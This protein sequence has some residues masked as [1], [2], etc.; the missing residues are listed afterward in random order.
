MCCSNKRK[1]PCIKK[2]KKKRRKVPY[3]LST[4]DIPLT[5]TCFLAYENFTIMRAR[6]ISPICQIQLML[7]AHSKKKIIKK[8]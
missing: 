2:K 1:V 7:L 6:A 8:K 5:I 4:G 3:G